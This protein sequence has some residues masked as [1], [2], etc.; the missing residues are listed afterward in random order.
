MMARPVFNIE[1]C[2]SCEMCIS[3][4]PKKILSLSV[5]FN[6]RGYNPAQCTDDAACIGCMM[7]ARMCPDTVIEIYK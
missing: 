6:S 3:V 5:F 2:K 1:K 4:C 7:C